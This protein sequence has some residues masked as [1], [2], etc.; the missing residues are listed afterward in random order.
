MTAIREES[1][2]LTYYD[3]K[4]KTWR[5]N[6]TNEPV[7]NNPRPCKRCGHYRTKEGYD[8][9][10]GHIRFA[11]AACCGHGNEKRRYTYY[12]HQYLYRFCIKTK[13]IIPLLLYLKIIK[14]TPNE[15]NPTKDDYFDFQTYYLYPRKIKQLRRRKKWP[16]PQKSK[17]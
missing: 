14:L 1:G 11:K 4:T 16:T 7:K 15:C 8:H 3:K 10:L 9:C 6:D 13:I 2:H 17:I 5:Y 12:Y